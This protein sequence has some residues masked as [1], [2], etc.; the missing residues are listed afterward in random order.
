MEYSD[1][2]TFGGLRENRDWVTPDTLIALLR[3]A[4]VEDVIELDDFERYLEYVHGGITFAAIGKHWI[5]VGDRYH[6]N[7]NRS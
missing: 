3:Q 1:R 4:Y 2:S 6:I 5:R 7:F